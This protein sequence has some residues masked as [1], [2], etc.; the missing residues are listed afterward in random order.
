M[1]VLVSICRSTVIN[2]TFTVS[3]VYSSHKSTSVFIISE[4][5]PYFRMYT[6]F[7]NVHRVSE[8]TPYSRM[9]TVFQNV[10][11]VSECTPCFRMYT[12]F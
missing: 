4:C 3:M 6:V 7:Q 5:T 2:V 10:H 12:V 11:R 9:Y 1:F 8:C